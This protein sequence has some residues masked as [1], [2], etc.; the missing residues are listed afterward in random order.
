MLNRETGE[1]PVLSRSCNVER[2]LSVSLGNWE[3]RASDEAE[4]EYLPNCFA[5]NSCDGREGGIS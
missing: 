5:N 4:P 1:I 3:G 2:A